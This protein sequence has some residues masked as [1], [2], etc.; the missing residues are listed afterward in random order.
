MTPIYFA[1]SYSGI[2]S[3]SAS[4][5]PAN[6]FAVTELTLCCVPCTLGPPGHWVP[7]SG[8]SRPLEDKHE[9]QRDTVT[10]SYS[11]LEIRPPL[12]SKEGKAQD[13]V[14]FI[15]P[16]EFI[17]ELPASSQVLTLV[18]YLEWSSQ[19]EGWSILE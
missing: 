16:C 13:R 3:P 17:R 5:S 18:L 8:V 1:H 11:R 10:W 14:E 4:F 15:K 19:S 9:T 7:S 6:L 2:T 12:K